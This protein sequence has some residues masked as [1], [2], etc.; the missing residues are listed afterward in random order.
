VSHIDVDLELAS[1]AKRMAKSAL[2][3]VLTDMQLSSARN[4]GS[5]PERRTGPTQG[6]T[7][8]AV[9]G[10]PIERRGSGDGGGGGR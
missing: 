6:I 7:R 4:R 1:L 10:P 5:F 8:A 9:V 3:A 2:A